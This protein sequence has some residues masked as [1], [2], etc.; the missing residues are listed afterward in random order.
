MTDKKRHL[1]VPGMA[2]ISAPFD[3]T[4]LCG[5]QRET[6]GYAYL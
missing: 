4:D 2:Q 5:I 3:V 6:S 1:P